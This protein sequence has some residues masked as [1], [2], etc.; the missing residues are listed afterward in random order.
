MTTFE[1]SYLGDRS[2][3]GP[4][5]GSSARSAG[6]STTRREGDPVWQIPP[7]TPFAELPPHWTCPNC[8]AAGPVPGAAPMTDASRRCCPIRPRAWRR[9]FARSTPRGCAGSRSSIRRSASRRSAFAPWKGYWLGV[10]LTPWF[11]NLMLAP[12]DPARWR[13]LPP[14]AKRRYAFP[15]GELRLHRRARRRRSASTRSARCSRRCSNS[16]TTRRRG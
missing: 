12:R 8:S 6:T 13:P 10:M 14:G 1:G 7:G 2:K 16:T 5:R 4:R 11:M 3:I 9:P 15:A